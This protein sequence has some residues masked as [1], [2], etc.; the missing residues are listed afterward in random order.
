MK[1]NNDYLKMNYRIEVVKDEIED[2]YILSIP[3]LKGCITTAETIEEGMI[4]IEDA[5][6]EWIKAAIEEGI[7]VPEPI[8]SNRY[9]G[10]FKLRMPKSLHKELMERA[11]K[12]GTSMN[13]YCVYLLSKSKCDNIHTNKHSKTAI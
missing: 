7:K 4:M 1:K 8:D 2:G 6:R 12:E 5:K 9:S 13:Q 3:E 11:K 10:Q